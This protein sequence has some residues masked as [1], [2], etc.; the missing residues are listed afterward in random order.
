[1]ASCVVPTLVFLDGVTT[2]AFVPEV[3]PGVAVTGGS[4]AEALVAPTGGSLLLL[5]GA[6]SVVR[7]ELGV[8]LGVVAS[9]TVVGS[10]LVTGAAV[11]PGATAA[12]VGASDTVGLDVGGPLTVR[13]T[14]TAAGC[15]DVGACVGMSFLPASVVGATVS[16]RAVGLLLLPVT[17]IGTVVVVLRAFC[18]AASNVTLS[19][20]FDT[21]VAPS[22]PL[23][24]QTP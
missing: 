14:A 20:F 1:M 5:L 24:E 15:A 9:F 22:V 23:T 7:G 21:D 18:V 10:A 6:G 12:W 4:T 16:R 19:G 2:D 3:L 8:A 13:V 17:K 11:M